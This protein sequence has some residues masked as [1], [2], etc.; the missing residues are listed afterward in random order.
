MS[1]ELSLLYLLSIKEV[2]LIIKNF[3]TKSGGFTG[4]FHQI[5]KEK[6]LNKLYNITRFFS[7]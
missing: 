4:E 2:E 7:L 3:L 5:F 6:I 1:L